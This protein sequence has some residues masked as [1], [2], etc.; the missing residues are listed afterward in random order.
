MTTD[1][2]HQINEDTNN[3]NNELNETNENGT[4]KKQLI[5]K[6]RPP[7][8]KLIVEERQ[9]TFHPMMDHHIMMKIIHQLD[10]GSRLRFSETCYYARSLVRNDQQTW[11]YEWLRRTKY[12]QKYPYHQG[13][14]RK[15]CQR[16]NWGSEFYKKIIDED[17]DTIL[18]QELGYYSNECQREHCIKVPIDYLIKIHP[19]IDQGIDYWAKFVSCQVKLSQY[20]SRILTKQIS[21]MKNKLKEAQQIAKRHQEECAQIESE[22]NQK[23]GDLHV[24][25]CLEELKESKNLNRNAP[26]GPLLEEMI[27][28]KHDGT[29]IFPDFSPQH[30][31][32]N[33]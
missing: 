11:Y 27:G 18:S 28:I 30:N 14:F 29:P 32:D 20:S 25:T 5:V 9:K 17:H 22:I 7:P 3:N 16:Y 21:T 13:V 31:K 15:E 19:L 10:I 8:Q 2:Y 1:N 4:K 24:R 23:Y 33:Y 6:L 12:H 26:N